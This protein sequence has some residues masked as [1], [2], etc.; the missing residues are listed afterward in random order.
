MSSNLFENKV[1]DKL[2][3][4]KSNTYKQNFTLNNPEW[5]IYHKTRCV[6][7]IVV[8]NGHG[9]KSSNPGIYIYIYIYNTKMYTLYLV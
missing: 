1:T 2:F 3:L 4:N 5:V 6:M 7:V 9:D 8:E